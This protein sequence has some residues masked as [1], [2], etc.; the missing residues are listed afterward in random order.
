MPASDR[1]R[2][3]TVFQRECVGCHR[4]DEK[5]HDIGPSLTTIR[6]RTP[7]E[8][9]THILDPNREVAQNFLQYV[10]ITDD[11]RTFTGVIG[12]ETATSVTLKRPEGA[13]DQILRRNIDEI[14]STGMS[15]MPEGLEKKIQPQEMADLI[16]YLLGG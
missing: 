8:V 13:T 3:R 11:G 9:L 14:S 16:A 1:Q 2:G 4:L 10:V 7:D 5:G 15:L 6:H 12:D